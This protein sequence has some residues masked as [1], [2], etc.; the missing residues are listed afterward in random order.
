MISLSRKWRHAENDMQPR[1]VDVDEE[2]EDQEVAEQI[3]PGTEAAVLNATDWTTET[4]ITQLDRGNIQLKPKFQRRDAWKPDRKSRFI[5]S[6]IV[7]LPIP[8]IVLAENKKER[9]KFIVL[10]GKQRLLSILQFWG[11]GDGPNNKYPLSGLTL[12]QELKG[13][14]F[15]DLR[16][17]PLLESDFNSLTNQSIRTVVI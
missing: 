9:G 10:D 5:E 4:I 1:D 3:E 17:N 7:G 16:D 12:R 8:Q 11:K 13:K 14:T 6:L 2:S 15:E